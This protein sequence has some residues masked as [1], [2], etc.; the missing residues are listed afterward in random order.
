MYIMCL[1]N[2]IHRDNLD[3]EAHQLSYDEYEFDESQEN[4]KSNVSDSD[5][6][7]ETKKAKLQSKL[8]D[9]ASL[10]K[11]ME[12]LTRLVNEPRRSL[13][14]DVHIVQT[15]E[16]HSGYPQNKDFKVNDRPLSTASVE[17]GDYQSA[18]EDVLEK[19]LK[20]EETMEMDLAEPEILSDSRKQFQA[21]E[22]F[23]LKLADYQVSVGSALEEGTKLLTEPTGLSKDEQNE[24][25]HQLYLLNE[26]WEALRIKALDTQT[27]VHKQLAKIQFEKVEELKKFLTKT[28]DRQSRMIVKGP[29][30]DELRQQ[31]EEHKELQADLEAQQAL[32]ES[33]SNLVI[34]E[35]SEYFRDLEDKLVA[36]EERWSHVVKWTAKRWDSLQDLS[37]KWTKLAEHHRILNLWIDTREKCLKDWESKQVEQIGDAMTRIKCLQ[38]CKSDLNSLL[39]SVEVLETSVGELDNEKFSTLNIAG[40]VE[41]LNDRIEAL[42]Q[43]LEV[44]KDRIDKMG[45]SINLNSERRASI[46]QG[47]EDFQKQVNDLET[48]VFSTMKAEKFEDVQVIGKKVENEKVTQLNET[49]MDMVYFI[50]E[51]EST[52]ND[53]YQLDAKDQIT[54]LEKM[55]EKLKLQLREHEKSKSLLSSCRDEVGHLEVEDQHIQE[56]GSKYEMLNFQIMEL[57]DSARIEMKKEKFMKIKLLLADMRDWYKQ[58]ANE[59]SKEEL[60]KKLAEMEGFV[61]EI[62]EFESDD[63]VSDGDEWKRDLKQLSESWTDMKSA[64]SRL[65]EEVSPPSPSDDAES[66]KEFDM[67]SE[68][69]LNDINDTEK[70]LEELELSTPDTSNEQFDNINDLFQIK[71][72]FQAMKESCDQMTIKFRELNEKGSDTLLQGDD[73]IQNKRDSKFSDLSKHLTKLISR[74]NEVT[75]RVYKRTAEL[76]Y[77]STQYGELKTLLVSE[78][79]YLDKLDKLLR[80]SPENAADAEEISEELDHIENY[81]RSNSSD[82]RIDKIQEIG[83]ELADASFLKDEIT[84]EIR[85]M[86]IRRDRLEHQVNIFLFFLT[87]RCF[88]LGNIFDA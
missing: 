85:K 57:I 43:I 33:L 36:L 22:D 52:M 31:M 17:I 56:L 1:Y 46:P 45:F 5:G 63:K 26:R 53:M 24:I 3:D 32:V 47:W 70:W 34:I 35:D 29:G 79:G 71:S 12:D 68:E 84:D 73:T 50:D 61:E 74:W 59:T 37:F 80:R 10:A 6:E 38:F 60:E 62:K 8:D 41:G 72:K 19:L 9:D 16:H 65:V 20:A 88:Y 14:G 44:Q 21:H 67:Q 77:L 18:I 40:K 25:K 39:K 54:I 11:S 82:A 76:E 13:I 86:L 4:N 78:A 28:E 64:I 15:L 83:K 2:S 66:I 27:K 42:T 51:I 75:T 58:H 69:I 49:I 23:M 7:S 55:Q 30:P 81:L 87:F 48:K